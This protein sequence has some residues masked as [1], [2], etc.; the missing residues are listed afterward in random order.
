[1]K[2][3]K[4]NISFTLN[5][6]ASE[7]NGTVKGNGDVII[8]GI[9]PIQ[10]AIEKQITFIANKAY[11][12]YLQDTKAS[13]VI[14]SP[15]APET[16][17]PVIINDNPYLTFA[18]VI[19]LLY[20]EE[21]FIDKG[22]DPSAVIEKNTK[23]DSSTGIGA[24]CHIRDGATIGENCQ[25]VSSVFIGRNVTIGDN[26]LLYPGVKILD[27]CKIGNNVIIHAGTV[28]GSDGFGYAESK[29][30]LYKIK[31]VGW[32]EI[33]NDVELGSN[34]SVDRGAIGPTKIGD[35]TKIDNLVQVGHNVE[36]GT[37]C[38]I[39]SQ[40]GIAG[41][42]K[43]GNRVILAGQVG[44]VGHL[45]IGDDVKVGAQSGVKDNLETGKTYF[46][47]PARLFMEASR[48]EASLRKLPDLLKRVKKLEQK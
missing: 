9:A 29:K 46:G 31:Q 37:D 8:N 43:I 45:I 48:I 16:D 21:K 12:K 5:E 11:Y 47:T 1:M 22:I 40:V 25:L 36:I 42:T 28:V 24:L 19:N 13:A 41:S 32:V 35:R 38:I 23:I 18:K 39:V 4:A 27:D 6:I 10:T 14:L 34:I 44:I 17:L 33:G 20:P 7:V 3:T 26:C 15:E 2:K 30:G